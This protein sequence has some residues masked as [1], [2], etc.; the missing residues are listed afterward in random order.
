MAVTAPPPRTEME[1]AQMRAAYSFILPAYV[2]YVCFV[3]APVILTLVLSFMYYDPQLGS[4][5]VGFENFTRFFTDDRSLKIFW[6]TL[7]FT[8]LAVTGN[9][10]IAAGSTSVQ[11]RLATT[12]DVISEGNE[13]FTLTATD[14]DGD[15]EIHGFIGRRNPTRTD[16][17][18]AEVVAEPVADL[19][20]AAG[21]FA[22]G[23]DADRVNQAS[24][25]ADGARVYVPRVGEATLPGPVSDG[26]GVAGG[27]GSAPPAPVD[28]NTATAEQ[29]D[30]LPGVGPATAERIA[31]TGRPEESPIEGV[32]GRDEI[33]RPRSRLG[34]RK[35]GIAQPACWSRFTR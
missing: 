8:A 14:P 24:A 6:N 35:S 27:G 18:N 20:A 28:L 31:A 32:D 15:M 5:W 25:L 21:G 9:V 17:D 34:L 16:E 33:G 13:T 30:T 4:K 29:L 12:D 2:L 11:L 23:A 10:S 7:R 26:G 22:P 19:V 1:R 3:L